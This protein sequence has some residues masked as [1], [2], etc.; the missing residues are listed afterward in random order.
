MIDHFLIGVVLL[1]IGAAL[2]YIGVPNKAGQ[3]PRFLR[4]D[5]S[6]VLYPPL[7]MIFGAMGVVEIVSAI[8]R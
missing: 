8:F 5:A 2:L 4:F 6:V 7:I 3:H 1:I